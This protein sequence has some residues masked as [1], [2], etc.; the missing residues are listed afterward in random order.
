[1]ARPVLYLLGVAEPAKE[2]DKKDRIDLLVYV[3]WVAV[4]LVLLRYL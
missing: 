4:L 1:V 3:L 2:G